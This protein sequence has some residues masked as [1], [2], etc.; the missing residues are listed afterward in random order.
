[1]GR[2]APGTTPTSLGQRGGDKPSSQPCRVPILGAGSWDREQGT[3]GQSRDPRGLMP[4]GRGCPQPPCAG[5]CWGLIPGK[6][7]AAATA[8]SRDRS[9]VGFCGSTQQEPPRFPWGKRILQQVAA[10]REGAGMWQLP[11]GPTRGTT[12]MGAHQ[13]VPSSGKPCPASPGRGTEGS[14]GWWLLPACPWVKRAAPSL[15]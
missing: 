7:G 15:P 10:L 11:A 3:E 8:F 5:I 4:A 1:M 2:T 13:N 14:R 9:S 6:L 12:G